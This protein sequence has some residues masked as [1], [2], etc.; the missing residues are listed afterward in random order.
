MLA[1]QKLSR[2]E[3]PIEEL[4]IQT[5]ESSHMLSGTLNGYALQDRIMVRWCFF[6]KFI[7]IFSKA[8]SIHTD[9]N[10]NKKITL[11]THSFSEYDLFLKL[12][13]S[14]SS[15]NSMQV[16]KESYC[17]KES[18]SGSKHWHSTCCTTVQGDHLQ[19]RN[20]RKGFNSGYDGGTQGSPSIDPRNDYQ[21][22]QWV[23][24]W[25]HL[26]L[27]LHTKIIDN[28]SLQ[29]TNLKNILWLILTLDRCNH[30]LS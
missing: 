7:I 18:L 21:W 8:L 2:N 26:N 12:F 27:P 22:I 23:C 11:I 29:N 17:G 15:L 10:K 16:G 5:L 14:F 13:F 19:V 30:N 28:L 24:E 9:I 25:M 6:S 3:K 20:C 1:L 4:P